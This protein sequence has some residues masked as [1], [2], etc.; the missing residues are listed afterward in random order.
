[1][2]GQPNIVLDALGTPRAQR[3]RAREVRKKLGALCVLGLLGVVCWPGAA[4]GATFTVS[5]SGTTGDVPGLVAAIAQ[6]NAGGGPNIVALE[7]GCVYTLTAVDNY[8]YGPKGLP[9]IA[10]TITIEGNGATIARSQAAG[11]PDFR[12]FF[13]GADPAR[14]ETLNYVS[15]GAGALTLS[16]VTLTGGLAQ[17]GRSFG[18]GG[19]AGMGGAIFSQGT[20]TIENSTLT[21]NIAQGG[22]AASGADAGGGIGTDANGGTGGG[23]GPGVFN[24]GSG[25]A[26]G[27]GGGGAGFQL[28]VNGGAASGSSPG[29]G[30]GSPAGLGGAGSGSQ[31]GDGGAGGSASVSGLA[32]GAGGGF[33][34]GGSGGG[35]LG[36]GGGGGGI[37]GGGGGGGVTGGGGGF[38]GG[39]GAASESQIAG[40]TTQQVGGNGG[41]GG[42]GGGSFLGNGGSAGAPGFGGGTPSGTIGGS[43]AGMGGAIFNMQGL[44]T[45][46]N[47]TLTGNSAAAGTSNPAVTDP[48]KGIAGAVF[49]LS[50]TVTTVASTIAG[51]SADHYASQ[52]LNV[53]YDGAQTRHAVTTLEDTIVASGSGGAGA[54]VA[55]DKSTHITPTQPAG[56][57]AL[58]DASRFDLL[59]TPI[60]TV[61]APGELG[62]ST[63]SPL[64]GNPLLGPLQDNG[65][66]TTTM[67]PA[68]GSPAID[69]G[70]SS[71]LN[72]D[73]RGDA[74]P[75]DFAGIL[76]AAGG[77][78]ADIGAF[79]LQQACT[80]QASPTQACRTLS[81]SR[82]GSGTGGVS[83]AGI[84][85]PPACS[86]TY[87][88]STTV[89]LTATPATG[90]RFAGWSGACSGSGTCSVT[91]AMDLAVTA[92]FAPQAPRPSISALSQS[93]S[94]W[95][96]GSRLA[97][98]TAKRKPPVGTV[99]SFN[100]NERA[101][102]TFTF[103]QRAA[104]RKVN[105]KCV[106]HTAKNNR[107]PRCT[108][109]MVAGTI[110][111]TAHPGRNSV[112][113]YGRLSKRR[114]LN[115]GRYALTLTATAAG[116]R[117]KSRALSFTIVK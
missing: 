46:R 21:G 109:I 33:G 19:G 104:G 50:G 5:C 1:M 4:V 85:C 63:G 13:V 106:A 76:N 43:G 53:V 88:D 35:F 91:M 75:F 48:G 22:A 92:R 116:N 112:H 80:N 79:E 18:G 3:R 117:T 66:L 111:F 103:T 65:G 9:P 78:G 83:G 69:A 49:N 37:G 95:R 68:A 86:S 97:Q 101:S 36:S 38:G 70:S 20:V 67:A 105:G 2:R 72:T 29:S 114:R 58:V 107:K 99:F 28:G 56:S 42:G 108:R 34:A 113:F 11:T 115:P 14:A 51:N 6:A 98:I 110:S 71:G 16:D 25:G 12:L 15:P 41:F 82:A 47:S 77:D 60:A 7:R 24:G 84:S 27:G 8:W 61:V 62:Q 81:V 93:A 17:G 23:F 30:G 57:T 54:D 10:S 64:L 89:V 94:V 39:G 45:I 96:G 100:L 102:L 26:G 31:S 55:S 44:L 87:A 32:G 59:S 52:I 73:Q 74:R 40:V 90:S